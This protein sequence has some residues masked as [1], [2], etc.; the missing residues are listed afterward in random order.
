MD[1]HL[2]TDQVVI[3]LGVGGRGFDHFRNILGSV[4]G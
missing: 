4:P 2:V 1:D 3:R